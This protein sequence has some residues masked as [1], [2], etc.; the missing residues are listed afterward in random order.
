MHSKH[1][2]ASVPKFLRKIT[3]KTD[4]KIH[5]K[6]PKQKHGTP[7][8]ISKRATEFEKKN[9]AAITSCRSAANGSEAMDRSNLHGQSEPTGRNWSG[10][11]LTR[12][13]GAGGRADRKGG[14]WRL[15]EER[16]SG[17]GG[18]VED[19]GSQQFGVC[20]PPN[21][22]LSSFSCSFI[23]TPH[24]MSNFNP[25]TLMQKVFLLPVGELAGIENQE[26]I[27]F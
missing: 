5:Q 27:L 2:G 16:V 17:S 21:K 15:R 3:A 8:G 26:Y 10:G 14:R 22:S 1:I 20:L 9:P 24:E 19:D 6:K 7:L 13:K 11:W 4:P 18:R 12:G 23:P 25:S